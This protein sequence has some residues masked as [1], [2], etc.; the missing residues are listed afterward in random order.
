MWVET[1]QASTG[2]L[3]SPYNSSE[4]LDMPR[5]IVEWLHLEEGEESPNTVS[6]PGLGWKTR[7]KLLISR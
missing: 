2:G 1:A 6:N 5:C 3:S 4:T 7:L